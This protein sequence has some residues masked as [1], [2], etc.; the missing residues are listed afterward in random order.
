VA[1]LYVVGTPLGNLEDLSPRAARVLSEVA[2]VA[3]EDT[4][5]AQRLFAS[6]GI[7]T[8]AVSYF[9][10]NEAARAA[11]LVERLRAGEDVALISEAGMP[12]LSDPGERLVAAAA[13]AG[14]AVEVV[15]GPS[16]AIAALVGSGLPSARFTFAGFLPREPE[17]RRAELARLRNRPE[18]LVLYES[19]N[20][21][22]ATLADAAAVFGDERRACVARELTKL[23][24][25]FARASLG[26]LARRYA[27]SGA[28]GEITLVIEGAGPEAEAP[29]IDLE[30]EIDKRLERGE[31]A[32]EIAAALALA[33][34]KPKRLIYQLVIMRQR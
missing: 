2:V 3:A 24:E 18:T 5:A 16:A 21:L 7:H 32:K 9:E 22:A 25:E 17:R 20:R 6:F 30:K 8:P 23:H 28:R 26:E 12:S 15:P 10:G 27:E 34:G 19:P 14:I 29:A 11:Q 1:K 33:T 13:A 4:R 31:S